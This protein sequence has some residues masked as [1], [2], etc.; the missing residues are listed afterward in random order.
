MANERDDGSPDDK[1]EPSPE[2]DKDTSDDTNDSDDSGDSKSRSPQPPPAPP[3]GQPSEQEREEQRRK[4]AAQTGVA[5]GQAAVSTGTAVAQAAQSGSPTDVASAVTS[6][7]SGAAGIA[8]AAAGPRAAEAVQATQTAVS[9]AQTTVQTAD[10]LS[11]A[12]DPSA[13]TAA[14]GGGA[15]GA[16]SAAGASPEMTQAVQT[17]TSAASSGFRF[18][19]SAEAISEALGL[20]P[21]HQIAHVRYEF[22]VTEGPTIDADVRRV[23][24]R[25]GLSSPYELTVDLILSQTDSPVDELLGAKCELLVDRTE[26]LRSVFGV[27]DRYEDRG[28]INDRQRIRIRIVPA[29]KLLDQKINSRVFQG[30]TVPQILDTV[31]SEALDLYGR[32]V[33]AASCLQR[34]YNKR[35]YC[36]QYRESALAF[37]SRLMEEEGI[38]YT[39]EPD[40]DTQAE[41]M[42]LYDNNSDY[43]TTPLIEDDEVPI[44]PDRESEASVESIQSLRWCWSRQPN[45]VATQEDNFK[46]PSVDRGEGE[47]ADEHHGTEREVF[48]HGERRQITEDPIEDQNAESFSGEDVQQRQ[49][50]AAQTLELHVRRTKVLRGSSNVTGFRPGTQFTLGTAHR[51]DLDGQVFLVTRVE[52]RGD[53]VGAEI[54]EGDREFSEYENDFEAIPI[55]HEYRPSV[56]TPKP[57]VQGIQLATVVGPSGQEIHTDKYGRIRARFAWDRECE[58]PDAA[59]CWMRV[60]QPW[61]GSN[62]GFVFIPRIGMEVVVHFIDGNPDRPMVSGSVYNESRKPPYTLPDDKT[63]SSIKTASSPGEDGYNELTF[64]DAAGSEQIIVHAQK[65]YNETVENN[66]STT[67][68]GSQTIGVDGSQST[69]VGG[70]QSNTV[71]GN[72]NETITKNVVIKV[73]G[74][75]EEEITGLEKITL[76]DARET[77]ITKTELHKVTEMLTQTYE[78]GRDTTI[79]TDDVTKVTEGNSE[80]EVVAGH[81]LVKAKTKIQ[82]AQ[83]ETSLL[84]LEDGATLSTDKDFSVTNGKVSVSS[85]GGKLKLSAADE[86][87]LT[88]GSASIVLKKDGSIDIQ[89]SKKAT[90]GTPGSSITAEPAAVSVNS[91]KIAATAMG[92]HEIKGALVK[93]N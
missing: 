73:E 36:V 34:E 21:E 67:V 65:D 64:E 75:R 37:C 62:W 77:T 17:A 12:S 22:T 16:M 90:M 32:Q 72:Q 28:V 93:I 27:I 85:E 48:L 74:T 5:A 3:A 59:T 41:V 53:A 10:A 51:D 84:T 30:A 58:A 20:D 70:D 87:S 68:H 43:P 18:D 80:L 61:A 91:A 45:K 8:G 24:M 86:L 79:K 40:V 55:A 56:V 11:N 66:H 14:V 13:A 2:Q 44:I 29:F 92:I 19:D 71:K 38:A 33:N 89:G 31:L 49:P 63:K 60:V 35:D 42:V 4:Q 7:A 23:S 88:C 81:R 69:S 76:K 83:K 54:N 25:E 82:L 26:T 78:A 9:A 47:A 50:I 15:Q 1:H 39:F 6:G 52:H 46:G 57:R